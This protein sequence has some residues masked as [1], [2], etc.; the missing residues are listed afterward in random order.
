MQ[1][2]LIC[3]VATILIVVFV[4]LEI[5]SIPVSLIVAFVTL[6]IFSVI[7]AAKTV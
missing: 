6:T 7:Y 2:L 5:F 4:S 3:L 1:D